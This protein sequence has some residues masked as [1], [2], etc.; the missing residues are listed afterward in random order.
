[1]GQETG[2]PG[3]GEDEPLRHKGLVAPTH[4]PGQAAQQAADRKAEGQPPD[5]GEVGTAAWKQAT[6]P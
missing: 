5:W 2:P 4:G 1:M 3:A 6:L